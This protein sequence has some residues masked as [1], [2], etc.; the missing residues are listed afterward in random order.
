MNPN[1][2]TSAK[3]IIQELTE[4]ESAFMIAYLK[5]S[6][7]LMR[8]ID[9]PQN[10]EIEKTYSQLLNGLTLVL[11]GARTAQVEKTE[12]TPDDPI[13]PSWAPSNSTWSKSRKGWVSNE[14][15]EDGD[16]EMYTESD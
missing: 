3:N 14:P 10:P 2:Y 6:P 9:N 12:P 5:A 13:R 16:Y 8:D 11:R 15:N 4:V 1:N 7:N